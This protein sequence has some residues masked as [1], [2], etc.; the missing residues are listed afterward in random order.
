DRDHAQHHA[1]DHRL[2][3]RRGADRPGLPRGR[4]L[5]VRRRR[6]GDRDH[7]QH[8]ALDHRLLRRRGADRPGLPRGRGLL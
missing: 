8:H 1:L 3:R 6:H 5:L 4:G 7:A 2:L